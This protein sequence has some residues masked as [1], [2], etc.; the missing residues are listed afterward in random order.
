MPELD[1]S[2][3]YGWVVVD[4]GDGRVAWHDGG[5]DWSLATVAEFRRRRIMVFWVSR[6]AG[7]S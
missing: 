7:W 6:T 1:G 2:Y 5:N 4:P 3:G